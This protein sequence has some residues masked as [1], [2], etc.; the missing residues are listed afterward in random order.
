M[1]LA[2]SLKRHA[3]QPS[4]VL[5]LS[6]LG[7]LSFAMMCALST[8]LKLSK[9]RQPILRVLQQSENMSNIDMPRSNEDIENICSRTDCM[10]LSP[11]PSA[12]A[13]LPLSITDATLGEKIT[14]E[15]FMSEDDG[16]IGA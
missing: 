7:N 9:A 11:F 16:L 6:K 3:Y 2:R 4:A 13:I 12:R 1:A 8:V 10:S 14:V 15:H 5:K